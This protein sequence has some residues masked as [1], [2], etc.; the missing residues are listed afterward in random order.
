VSE[1][2]KQKRKDGTL[3][4]SFQV[5]NCGKCKFWEHRPEASSY[6]QNRTVGEC[7][8]VTNEFKSILIIRENFL[9]HRFV[10]RATVLTYHE[11]QEARTKDK[12]EKK[13]RERAG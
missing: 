9:C 6:H 5:K 7:M 8:V 3:S 11:Y 2:E 1:Q 12:E 13:E 4:M 10:D